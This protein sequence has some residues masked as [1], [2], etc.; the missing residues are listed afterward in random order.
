MRSGGPAPERGRSVLFPSIGPGSSTAGSALSDRL[1]PMALHRIVDASIVSLAVVSRGANRR[2]WALKKSAEHDTIQRVVPIL[3]GGED[4]RVAHIVVAEPDSVEDGGLGTHDVQD[5]WDPEAIRKA[6]HSFAR[7]GFLSTEGHFLDERYGH[8][9]ESWIAPAD[10]QLGDE[11]VKAGAWVIGFEPTAEGRAAIDFGELTGV[12]IEGT[13]VRELVKQEAPVA[14]NELLK[15]PNLR[16]YRKLRRRG[17]KYEAALKMARQAKVAP[18]AKA[19]LTARRR[20]ALPDSAFALGDRRYPIHSVGHARA[21]LAMV[22]A[23]GSPDE[24]AK[25]R[26]AVA[27]RYPQIA[28]AKLNINHAPPGSPQ[29]GQFISA[30]SSGGAATGASVRMGAGGAPL[31]TAQIMAFQRAHGL[32]VDGII[33]SQTAAALLGQKAG[34]GAISPAQL[35]ALGGGAAGAAGK[36]GSRSSGRTRRSVGSGRSR[37]SHAGSGRAR[38]S[39]GLSGVNRAALAQGRAQARAQKHAAARQ[40]HVQRVHAARAKAQARASVRAQKRAAAHRR[41]LIAQTTRA[42][43]AQARI[44]RANANAAVRQARA[45]VRGTAPRVRVAPVRTV[46]S[47][48]VTPHARF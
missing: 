37:S 47:S 18:V 20:R 17:L 19:Q 43:A 29:G 42:A 48:R 26:R 14:V 21:A 46:G 10:V 27:R 3:K 44:A 31:T 5:V 45:S 9:V 25:V 1:T 11:L 35:A 8:V 28:I 32:Q 34:I 2:Q 15:P 6:A 39:S 12:S 30:G 38:S 7:G 13:G 22:A 40:A 23:H 4:W 33:G 36:G 24:K 41:T 16:T